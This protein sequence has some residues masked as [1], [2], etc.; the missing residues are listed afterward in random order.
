M[1][2]APTPSSGDLPES[3]N[4]NLSGSGS[5]ESDLWNLDHDP[6]TPIPAAMRGAIGDEMPPIKSSRVPMVTSAGD[7]KTPALSG[8]EATKEKISQPSARK[9]EERGIR[10]NINPQGEAARP[11]GQHARHSSHLRD[12]TDLEQWADDG[13]GQVKAGDALDALQV[14]SAAASVAEPESAPEVK[15]PEKKDIADHLEISPQQAPVPPAEG[16]EISP[17]APKAAASPA[18]VSLTPALKFNKFEKFGVVLLV[19]ALVAVLAAVLYFS[20]SRLP[21]ETIGSKSPKFPIKGDLVLVQSATSYWRDVIASGPDADVVRRGTRLL[22]VLELT[23]KGGPAVVR[24]IFRDEY[25]VS[26][27]D[28]INRSVADGGLL[29]IPAT[30]GFEE[31]GIHAAYRT[32]DSKPWKIEVYEG[33]AGSDSANGFRKLFEMDIS[34]ERR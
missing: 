11:S 2:S 27:G 23:C 7:L 21:T 4:A 13:G 18:R 17:K 20:A 9:P 34:S 33:E 1:N 5:L 32:G 28:T 16:I 6:Q 10:L 15:V 12:F 14:E 3:S 24:V 22:P 31:I 19:V 30:A 25:G 8:P 29:V 26:M